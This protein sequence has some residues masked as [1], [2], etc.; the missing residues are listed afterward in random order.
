MFF[1][2][3]NDVNMISRLF[4]MIID[5]LIYEKHFKNPSKITKILQNSQNPWRQK[6]VLQNFGMDIWTKCTAPKC[7]CLKFDE[8]IMHVDMLLNSTS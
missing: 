5:N 1:H 6:R 7:C 3:N 4:Y 2:E 8:I